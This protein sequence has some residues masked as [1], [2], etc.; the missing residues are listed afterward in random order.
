MFDFVVARH[1]MLHEQSLAPLFTKLTEAQLRRQP[2]A[3][4]NSVAWNIWHLL[5]IEDITLNRFVANRPQVHTSGD[6]QQRMGIP[7]GHM[8]TA[9]SLEDVATLSQQM[10]LHEL[11]NYQQAVY[12]QSAENLASLDHQTLNHQ[13]DAAHMRAVVAGEAV[14][15]PAITEGVINYWGALSIGRFVLDY[16]QVHPNMHVGEIGVITG[17]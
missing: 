11:A 16:T 4:M 2:T 12:A 15:I 3:T 8:G 9:M 7:F 6:W 17:M 1:A 5:R 10:N 13:W 14:C